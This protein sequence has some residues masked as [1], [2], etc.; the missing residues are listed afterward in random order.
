MGSMGSG[1]GVGIEGGEC[2]VLGSDGAD[3]GLGPSLPPPFSVFPPPLL[4]VDVP[5]ASSSS[6]PSLPFECGGKGRRRVLVQETSL[7]LL[8]SPSHVASAGKGGCSSSISIMAMGGK[9]AY[10]LPC[11]PSDDADKDSRDVQ[12]GE[13]RIVVS[14]GR[15]G[16]GGDGEESNR[17]GGFRGPSNPEKIDENSCPATLDIQARHDHIKT[18]NSLSGGGLRPPES[19]EMS[20]ILESDGAKPACSW[21]V[22]C[23][24]IAHASLNF[25]EESPLTLHLSSTTY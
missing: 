23:T 16:R 21:S 3:G 4:S 1:E 18:A 15:E 19:G 2:G 10:L 13:R 22:P 5:P 25:E 14:G 6:P 20:I 12:G 11:I 24:L 8:L 7:F 9:I 17:A